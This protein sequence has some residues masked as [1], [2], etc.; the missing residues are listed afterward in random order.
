MVHTGYVIDLEAGPS[1]DS[2]VAVRCPC[3]RLLG[4]FTEGS[5]GTVKCPKCSKIVRI[6]LPEETL[7]V[8]VIDLQES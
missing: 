6:G 7:S 3:G 4:Y 1:R 2:E 8:P 5:R